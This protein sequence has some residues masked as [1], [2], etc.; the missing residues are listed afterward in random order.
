MSMGKEIAALR[1]KHAA[2]NLT[3]FKLRQGIRKIKQKYGVDA[4]SNVTKIMSFLTTPSPRSAIGRAKAK[5]TSKKT[6]V[7]DAQKKGQVKRVSTKDMEKA[8][9]AKANAAHKT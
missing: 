2:G 6:T 5:E 4:P 8:L 7:S 1:K 9:I 3:D